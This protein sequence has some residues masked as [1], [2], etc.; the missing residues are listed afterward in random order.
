MAEARLD[1]KGQYAIDLF[2][3]HGRGQAEGWNV[4]AHEAATLGVLLKE[5]T[6]IAQRHEI[7]R[8]GEGGGSGTDER[9][10]FAV[11][12]GRNVGHEGVDLA[13][14]VGGNALEAADGD[15]LFLDPTAAAR[16]LARTIAH[17]SQ[18]AGKD[19]ALPVQH[20]GSSVAALGDEP[21]VFGD[22]SVRGTG[23]LA[24]DHLVKVARVGNVRRGRAAPAAL[25]HFTRLHPAQS[26]PAR[27]LLPR[28]G[29]RY[30]NFRNGTRVVFSTRK[31]RGP[32][33]QAAR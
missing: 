5:H 7:A 27:P 30:P 15:R 19:V 33:W 6:A 20:K 28:V 14:V 10:A 29:M 8:H 23:P 17:A 16:G 4:R 2:I 21:D 18:N 32:L 31:Q 11:L 3:E 9:H 12:C 1:A 25:S 22:G 13:L 24:I 26:L